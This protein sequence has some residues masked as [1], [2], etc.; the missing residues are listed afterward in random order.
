[1]VHRAAT[2]PMKDD[3]NLVLA[4]IDGT[5]FSAEFWIYITL[6]YCIPL[7]ETNDRFAVFPACGRL[8]MQA[9][10]AWL[11]TRALLIGICLTV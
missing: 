2:M 9:P 7:C 4:F 8:S 10:T 5:G 1:M 11:A 3:L 6:A